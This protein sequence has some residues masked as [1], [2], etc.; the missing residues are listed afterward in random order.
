MSLHLDENSYLNLQGSNIMDEQC[1]PSTPVVTTG[2]HSTLRVA[3]KENFPPKNSAKLSKVSFQTPARDPVTRK[4]LS[5]QLTNIAFQKAGKNEES[6]QNIEGPGNLNNDKWHKDSGGSSEVFN[7]KLEEQLKQEVN[8]SAAHEEQVSSHGT[9]TLDLDMLDVINPFKSN[10]KVMNSP[11]QKLSDHELD[12]REECLKI[13]PVNNEMLSKKTEK[14]SITPPYNINTDHTMNTSADIPLQM[15]SQSSYIERDSEVIISQKLSSFEVDCLE[16]SDPCASEM[17]VEISELPLENLSNLDCDNTGSDNSLQM[18]GQKLETSP[19]LDQDLVSK[20]TQTAVDADSLQPVKLEIAFDTEVKEKPP[21][22]KLGKRPVGQLRP[23]SPSETTEKSV[24]NKSE[25][26]STK[27]VKQNETE[28]CTLEEQSKEALKLSET[29]PDDPVVPKLN[30]NIDWDKLDDPNFNPFGGVSKIC[31]SPSSTKLPAANSALQSLQDKQ[32]NVEPT[33]NKVDELQKPESTPGTNG[34]SGIIKEVQKQP[35][36]KNTCKVK[37]MVEVSAIPLFQDPQVFAIGDVIESRPVSNFGKRISDRV[38]PMRSEEMTQDMNDNEFTMAGRSEFLDDIIEGEA[39]EFR[40]ADQIPTF[41]Q[42]IEVDYLEQFGHS[43]FHASALRKQSLYLKFDPLLRE[44]PAKVTVKPL[45]ARSD[46]ADPTTTSTSII[47][48]E[49]RSVILSHPNE[50]MVDIAPL[51][52]DVQSILNDP[53]ADF[54]STVPAEDAIVEVLKYSQKDMDAAI[55]AVKQ[56][57]DTAMLAVKQE[58]AHQE[59][60]TLEWKQ[61]YEESLA[62]CAEMKKVVNQYAG[63]YFSNDGYETWKFWHCNF[64]LAMVNVLSNEASDKKS[65]MAKAELEKVTEEKQQALKEL[66]SVETSFSELF[67]RFEKQKEVLEGYRKN[68][69]CLKKCAQ[70]YLARIKKEEQR[71]QALKAHAEEKLNQANEEIAQVRNKYK[72]EVAAVQ[73]HLRKEQMK[74]NSLERSLEDKAK[75]N[76]ELSKICDELISKMEKI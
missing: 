37:P 14:M 57:A 39:E 33:A 31:N 53:V 11:V 20:N 71:Y 74:V 36:K 69:D 38:Q 65:E 26:Q 47:D 43:M 48:L 25:E 10:S 41:N 6:A 50:G 76:V 5:P 8:Q 44:S 23:K 63:S 3:Q 22:K 46:V 56:E 75:E 55:Q 32:E 1:D 45:E 59:A 49:T 2:R 62:Q 9:Y 67:K 72:A 66:N 16:K 28:Y 64:P 18:E 27:V 51:V 35:V 7:L 12:S 73:A 15:E 60:I 68:E 42:P 29:D 54:A 40:P 52:P 19:A 21:P 13:T 34:S 70:D 17:K 30:Y 4:V 24:H 58:L 61:Q